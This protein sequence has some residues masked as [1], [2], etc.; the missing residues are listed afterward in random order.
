VNSELLRISELKKSIERHN[1]HYKPNQNWRNPRE[2]NELKKLMEPK[3][4]IEPN[5]CWRWR[6]KINTE[7]Q[8]THDMTEVRVWGWG[9]KHINICEGTWRVRVRAE[10]R[11]H[12]RRAHWRWG[13]GRKHIH[14][15]GGHIGGWGRGRKH[16]H[17]CRG[18]IV[19]LRVRAKIFTHTESIRVEWMSRQQH[20][21]AT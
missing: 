10:T 16:I 19:C 4:L 13:W 7:I 14:I 1:K 9:R 2:P 3:E 21:Y 15:R 20:T 5:K 18:H 12:S 17:T 11:T 6:L 8:R